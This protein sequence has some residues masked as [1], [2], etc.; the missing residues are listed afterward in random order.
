MLINPLNY[1]CLVNPQNIFC[2]IWNVDFVSI[3]NIMKT[4]ILVD[5]STD[6][7]S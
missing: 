5:I 6:S 4:Y 1:T 7:F 3:F 2:L